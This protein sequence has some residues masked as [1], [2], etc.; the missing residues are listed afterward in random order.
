MSDF[1]LMILVTACYKMNVT[2]KVRSHHIDSAI[3]VSFL[4]NSC[5]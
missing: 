1:S 5:F 2:F 4:D 3:A